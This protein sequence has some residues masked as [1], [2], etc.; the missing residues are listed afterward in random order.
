MPRPANWFGVAAKLWCTRWTAATI[1]SSVAWQ[2]LVITLKIVDGQVYIN[3]K[4]QQ[5]HED[6]QYHYKVTVDGQINPDVFEKLGIY[7]S[8]NQSDIRYL[9]NGDYDITLTD[10]A[11]EELRKN[12]KVK[13]IEKILNPDPD[14]DLF[15]HSNKYPWKLDDYGPLWIPKKGVNS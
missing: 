7:N 4:P 15:P 8:D 10:K 6:M 9:A 11:V 13:A 5:R 1:T 14:A 12:S 3:S 2:Y